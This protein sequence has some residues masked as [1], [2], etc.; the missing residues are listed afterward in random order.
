MTG[1]SGTIMN[2]PI[3][4]SQNPCIEGATV[5]R[6]Y[7]TSHVLFVFAFMLHVSTND[8]SIGTRAALF[9]FF[10]TRY[11][12]KRKARPTSSVGHSATTIVRV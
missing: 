5:F 8:L 12:K 4:T 6:S 3:L 7:L 10:R 11:E 2:L 1:N 9:P